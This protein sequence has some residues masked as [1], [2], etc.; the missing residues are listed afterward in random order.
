MAIFPFFPNPYMNRYYRP[1]IY[2]NTNNVNANFNNEK[3]NFSNSN[4]AN[5]YN[6]EFNSNYYDKNCNS[7]ASED[8]CHNNSDNNFNNNPDKTNH[9]N[10]KNKSSR[11]SSFGPIQF[12]N[13][14]SIDID[15]PVLEV[16]GISLYLD[17][18]IILGLLFFLYEEGV[19]DDMLFLQLVLLLLS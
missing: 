10:A 9:S 8:V 2:P 14:L 13:P 1:N 12:Q 7:N 5:I 16:L 4:Y 11:Y 17:D 6:K 3:K 18:L 19:K 15:E